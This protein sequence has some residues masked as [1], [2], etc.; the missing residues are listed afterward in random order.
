MSDI[1]RDSFSSG[2][3]SEHDGVKTPT[4][5]SPVER[6]HESSLYPPESEGIP[7]RRETMDRSSSR[8]SGPPDGSASNL[9]WLNLRTG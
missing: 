9:S 6:R 7:S 3:P 2:I 1:G 4:P 8:Y 5:W